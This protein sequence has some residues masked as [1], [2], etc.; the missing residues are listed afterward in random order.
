M[1][2]KSQPLELKGQFIFPIWNIKTRYLKLRLKDKWVNIFFLKNILFNKI[3]RGIILHKSSFDSPVPCTSNVGLTSA[4][5]ASS[6]QWSPPLYRCLRR[7]NRSWSMTWD[8]RR[9]GKCGLRIGNG[10]LRDEVSPNP[11]CPDP[12]DPNAYILPLDGENATVC[13]LMIR[14]K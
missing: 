6:R 13:R 12:P 1:K 7:Y 5:L 9:P 10:E 4:I 2:S 14:K 11:S 3:S 8:N